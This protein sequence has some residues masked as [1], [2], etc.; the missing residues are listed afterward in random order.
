MDQPWILRNLTTKQFVRAEAIALRPEYVH[1]PRIEGL[2]F[3]HVVL[4]RTGWSSY[5][6]SN[7][8]YML[9][10]NH[11]VDIARGVWAG[12]CFDITTLAKHEETTKAE[13]WADVSQEVV[14]EIDTIYTVRFGPDWKKRFIDMPYDGRDS[15]LKT[16]PG[17]YKSH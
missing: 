15:L 14:K 6:T 5:L 1:G 3:G 12:H 7:L 16:R 17:W 10:T 4:A 9:K 8:A 2:G 13:E 11:A